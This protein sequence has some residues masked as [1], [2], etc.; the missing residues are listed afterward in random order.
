MKLTEYMKSEWIGMRVYVKS[1]RRG[2]QHLTQFAGTIL[3]YS[4]NRHGSKD[5]RVL[6]KP[7]SDS[8]WAQPKWC[9]PSQVEVLEA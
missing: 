2:M 3:D 4:D 6:I 8:I 5:P 7:E 9:S 1:Q